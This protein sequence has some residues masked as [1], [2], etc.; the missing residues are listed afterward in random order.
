MHAC[1]QEEE[2]EEEE[3]EVIHSA[4]MYLEICGEQLVHWFKSASSGTRTLVRC[5]YDQLDLRK[6]KKKKKKMMMMMIFTKPTI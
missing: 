5:I 2:E 1:I 6:K 4:W 3:E